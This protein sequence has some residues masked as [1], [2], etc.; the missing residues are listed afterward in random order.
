MNGPKAYG[1]DYMAQRS[2][3]TDGTSFQPAWNM[4]IRISK[5]IGEDFK[6][7]HYILMGQTFGSFETP[8]VEYVYRNTHTE[9]KTHKFR[10]WAFSSLET[11]TTKLITAVWLRP[12][13]WGFFEGPS[14]DSKFLWGNWTA[15]QIQL[16][17][18]YLQEKIYLFSICLLHSRYFAKRFLKVDPFLALRGHQIAK[19]MGLVLVVFWFKYAPGDADQSLQFSG[20]S[21]KRKKNP[22][23]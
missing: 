7:I 8:I 17:Q 23:K 20:V 11:S 13:I 21:H 1:W 18:L 10:G 14:R 12:L 16:Q 22:L 6:S 3:H 4:Q 9:T 19:K 15:E 5:V 2:I